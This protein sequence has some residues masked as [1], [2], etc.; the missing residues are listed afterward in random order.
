MIRKTLS[1]FTLALVGLIGISI[2]SCKK[3]TPPK[4]TILVVDE[5]NDPVSKARVI[6]KAADSDSAHTVIYLADGPV[7]VADTTFTDQSGKISLEFLYEAIY[8]V[9]VAKD[10]SG[11]NPSRRGI[12]ALILKNNETYEETVKITPQTM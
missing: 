1:I 12:G 10:G 6:I 5:D 2:S 8:K 4:A 3:S 9:E 7:K 11:S